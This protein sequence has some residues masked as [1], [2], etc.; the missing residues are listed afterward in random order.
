MRKQQQ[1]QQQQEPQKRVLALS[2]A[3]QLAAQQAQKE[4]DEQILKYA[5]FEELGTALAIRKAEQELYRRHEQALQVRGN[6]GTLRFQTRKWPA[7]TVLRTPDFRR[8]LAGERSA[9]ISH[10]VVDSGERC[11]R[12]HVGYAARQS[13]QAHQ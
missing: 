8:R 12:G 11:A 6:S 10:P 7:D 2:G 5:G 4:R 13:S 3:A 1:Q 9:R